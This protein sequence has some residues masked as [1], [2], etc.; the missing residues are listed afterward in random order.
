MET[1]IPWKEKH[2]QHVHE[3]VWE[4]YE[5]FGIKPEDILNS[6]PSKPRV[7]SEINLPSTGPFAVI[8]KY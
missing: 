7:N 3:K 8:V 5:T 1:K 2:R 4:V 6:R